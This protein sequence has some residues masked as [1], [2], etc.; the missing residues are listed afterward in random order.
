MPGSVWNPESN[1]FFMQ[2]YENW[3]GRKD[4]ASEVG[5]GYY[6]ARIALAEYLSRI[7]KQASCL[8]LRECRPEYYAPCGVGVLRETCRDAF[9]KK[10]EV[11]G[12]NDPKCKTPIATVSTPVESVN[13]KL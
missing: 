5:G 9:S 3:H 4:Y 11:F 10:P 2:D 6:V 7:R 13:I 8:V 1:I 12:C